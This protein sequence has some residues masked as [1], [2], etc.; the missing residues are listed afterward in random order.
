MQAGGP[1]LRR[2]TRI[3]RCRQRR[4][5]GCAPSRAFR[6]GALPNRRHRSTP[7]YAAGGR[8]FIFRTSHS[9]TRTRPASPRE[10][11]LA[12]P[13]A[14]RRAGLLAS[15]DGGE[16][17]LL[18]AFYTNQSSGRSTNPRLT[19]TGGPLKPDFG[20][21]GFSSTHLRRAANPGSPAGPVLARWRGSSIP[22]VAESATP[23]TRRI[24]PCTAAQST[25]SPSPSSTSC[26]PVFPAP[27]STDSP[28]AAGL[29]RANLPDVP[30][31]RPRAPAPRP[32]SASSPTGSPTAD[33]PPPAAP[34]PPA[35]PLPAA[36]ARLE[37]AAPPAPL[38]PAPSPGSPA[39]PVLARW[40]DSPP[41][42][43]SDIPHKSSLPAF[44]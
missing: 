20:L 14:K 41:P 12:R 13:I 21:S 7:L 44:C 27:A 30:P 31:A 2:V 36:A 42:P 29:P 35:L 15:P 11:A 34:P 39:R 38:G 37:S 43:S 3:V 4:K 23:A 19:G 26:T 10:W 9:L 24:S 25:L 18:F 5:R 32:A 22:S 1:H 17:S 16:D 40:G 8:T 6:E 33:E 28:P